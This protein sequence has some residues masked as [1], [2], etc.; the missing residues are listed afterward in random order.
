M[1]F[2]NARFHS[3]GKV[4]KGD[5]GLWMFRCKNRERRG[6]KCNGWV[7]VRYRLVDEKPEFDIK[8]DLVRTRPH[9]KGCEYFKTNRLLARQPTCSYGGQ[10]ELADQHQTDSED[11]PASQSTSQHDE[12][13]Q[14]DDT[15]S[16]PDSEAFSSINSEVDS[17]SHK[18]DDISHALNRSS[19]GDE[20]KLA[21][22]LKV[23]RCKGKFESLGTLLDNFSAG[24]YA[25]G[26]PEDSFDDSQ[27]TLRNLSVNLYT[28]LYTNLLLNLLSGK[29]SSS[30]EGPSDLASSCSAFDSPTGTKMVN[31]DSADDCG[32]LSDSSCSKAKLDSGNLIE[33]SNFP[34]LDKCLVDT[35]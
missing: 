32:S 24:S 3:K 34:L 31:Q 20:E 16:A 15:G 8:N 28:T 33:T 7:K 1:D 10:T 9:E 30:P 12:S 27:M 25:A 21:L 26:K 18:L 23:E 5:S 6:I 29:N 19:I 13:S 17:V 14:A 2:A 22:K 11:S 35:A 4:G